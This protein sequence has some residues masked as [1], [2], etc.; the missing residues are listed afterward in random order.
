MKAQDLVQATYDAQKELQVEIAEMVSKKI[1]ELSEKTGLTI[2][3]INISLI[4]SIA[5]E[6][7][8]RKWIVSDIMIGTRLPDIIAMQ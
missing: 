8:S 3:D 6:D 2:E 1:N 5:Y 4:E 7:T